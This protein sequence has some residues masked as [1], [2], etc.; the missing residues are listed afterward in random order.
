[1]SQRISDAHRA[2]R[3]E[4]RMAL[5]ALRRGETILRQLQRQERRAWLRLMKEAKRPLP[6]EPRRRRS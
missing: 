2:A 1:M 3:A 6:A 4:W 5:F